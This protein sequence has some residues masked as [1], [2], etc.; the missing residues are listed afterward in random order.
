[1]K[2]KEAIHKALENPNSEA[3]KVFLLE[4]GDGKKG[5]TPEADGAVRFNTE[6]LESNKKV[7]ARW[8]KDN[9][10]FEKGAVLSHQ[11]FA[12]PVNGQWT[13][14]IDDVFMLLGVLQVLGFG[15]VVGNTQEEEVLKSKGFGMF[16][17]FKF[18]S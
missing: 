9:V 10:I 12:T 14:N 3:V 8:L 2:L 4:R 7:F 16:P 17:M 11:E 5:K 13:N 15:K 1:M 18:K 6:F